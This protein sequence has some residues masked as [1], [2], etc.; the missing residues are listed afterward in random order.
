MFVEG[1]AP[2]KFSYLK[3]FYD[4]KNYNQSEY[5]YDCLIVLDCGDKEIR[6][7]HRTF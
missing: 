4:I 2:N 6:R 7:L 3:G 1:Q 5:G